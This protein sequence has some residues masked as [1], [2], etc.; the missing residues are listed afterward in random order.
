MRTTSRIL[1]AATAGTLSL[2]ALP[3]VAQTTGGLQAGLTLG[4]GVLYDDGAWKARSDL[5]FSFS[6]ATPVQSFGITARGGLEYP[7]ASDKVD[8][9]DPSLQLVYNRIGAN[10]EF[11]ALAEYRR[12]DI[13]TLEPDETSESGELIAGTGS[14]DMINLGSRL[15]FGTR[16][17]IGGEVG[18]GWRRVNYHDTGTATLYDYD[19]ITAD[20]TLRFTVDP[21]IDLRLTGSWED[22]ESEG[23]GRDRRTWAVGAGA[24]LRVNQSLTATADVRY[25]E[26]E[27]S[28]G[29]VTTTQTG[30]GVELGLIQTVKDGEYR[31]TASHVVTANGDRQTIRLRRA[32]ELK[33][34]EL[35]WSA[36]VTRGANDAIDGLVGFDYRRATKLGVLSLAA[37]RE[38]QADSFGEEALVDQ[39]RLGYR[40]TLSELDSI[41][42]SAAYRNTD[43][44][45]LATDS[46]E[47][48]SLGVTYRRQISREADLVANYAHTI[49]QSGSVDESENSFYLGLQRNFS[50]RP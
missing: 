46:I 49:K 47:Q 2:L 45:D 23:A 7:D 39:L 18:A 28:L 11:E 29:G 33:L 5:G 36:G 17:L 26:I 34:G 42:A 43:Y 20:G 25:T 3:A 21:R 8:F 19:T 24:D 38:I 35:S 12:S 31:L 50:W 6:S 22:T 10:A 32:Q 16:S 41:E 15:A 40:H 1:G 14:R 48:V 4:A 37:Y 13:G 44:F 30:P 27:T 9:A